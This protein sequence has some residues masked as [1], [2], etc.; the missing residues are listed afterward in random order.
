[1]TEGF[2]RVGPLAVR[3]GDGEV[4]MRRVGLELAYRGETHAVDSE[5]LG[6]SPLGILVYF[7]SSSAAKA[8]DASSI[9]TFLADA[10]AF[11]G[12]RV[13]WL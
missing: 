13:E 3:S 8:P 11:Y 5:M 9:R 2:E 1:M 12:L 10:L 6:G 7:E 4:L